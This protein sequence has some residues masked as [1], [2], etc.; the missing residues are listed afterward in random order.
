MINADI[1]I[2][3]LKGNRLFKDI[4]E[5]TLLSVCQNEN[6]YIK[7]FSKDDIIYDAASFEKAAG[8][9]VTGKVAVFKEFGEHKTLMNI[10]GAGSAFGAASL[11]GEIDAYV[12][13]IVAKENCE[14]IFLN[15]L[16]CNELVRTVPDFAVSYIAFLSDRIRFLNEKISSYTAPSAGVRLAGYLLSCESDDAL[17]DLNMKQLAQSLDIGRASLYRELDILINSGIIE[18]NGKKITIIDR[19]ALSNILNQVNNK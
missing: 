16:L 17:S 3:V 5:E 7:S 9:I 10:L 19:K 4:A 6:C 2:K 11:F 18:K 1:Y 12:T 13:T 15:Y 8:I 14:I